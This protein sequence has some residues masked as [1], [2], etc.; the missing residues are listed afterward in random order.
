[1]CHSELQSTGL[2]ENPPA[3]VTGV[4]VGEFFLLM[5]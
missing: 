2:A 5:T 3:V 1:M 4:G